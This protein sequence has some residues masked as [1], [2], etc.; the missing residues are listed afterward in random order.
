MSDPTLLTT[1]GGNIMATVTIAVMMGAVWVCKN[2]CR[3][4]RWSVNSGCLKCSGDDIKTERGEP[5]GVP[6]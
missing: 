4:Q 1:Y 5:P 3:H 2:K 6:V